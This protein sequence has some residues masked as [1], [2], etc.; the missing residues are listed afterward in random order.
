MLLHEAW[1]PA[2]DG[3]GAVDVPQF[4]PRK[5][6]AAVGTFSGTTYDWDNP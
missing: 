2:Q 6:D 3:G 5:E 1:P 4:R